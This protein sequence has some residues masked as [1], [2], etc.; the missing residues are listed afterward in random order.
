MT[1]YCSVEV[2]PAEAEIMLENLQPLPT[3]GLSELCQ[4]HALM[5]GRE[6]LNGSKWAL[7]MLDSTSKLQSGL[8][9]GNI[10]E[11]GNFDECLEVD[12]HEEWGS[13]V[14]QHC[15]TIFKFS[16]P[17][18]DKFVGNL[19]FLP[20]I[21]S[22]CMPSTCTPQDLQYVLSKINK[23]FVVDP[24]LCHTKNNG[25]SL[26][27]IDWIVI[28]LFTLIGV[29]CILS[30][31][32]DIFVTNTDRRN[33]ILL[34]FS[35]KTNGKALFNTKDVNFSLDAV[36]GMRFLSICAIVL[37][38]TFAL[39][40]ATP[41]T[42]VLQIMNEARQWKHLYFGNLTFAVD[43]F[44]VISGMLLCY[45]TLTALDAGTKFNIPVFYIHRFLRITPLLGSAI[46]L[47][48]SFLDKLGSGPI[49]NFLNEK[50]NKESCVENWWLTILNVQNYVHFDKEC[51]SSS[52]F[53]AVDTQ[54]F[55]ISPIF[56]L[57][58]HKW[59]KF[60]LGL[61]ITTG[62]AGII[63]AFVE[64][65]TRQDDA[66]FLKIKEGGP[67]GYSY[68][69]TH[70]RCPSWFVGLLCGYLLHR[71]SDWRKRVAT[72]TDR[73]SKV[74][75]TLGW[76]LTI[77]AL[78]AVYNSLYP[79]LQKDHKYDVL[80]AAFYCALT[81]PVWSICM[82]WIIF[83]CVSGYG[84]I[85][86]TI[87]S[88]KVWRPLGRLAF[89]MYI[90]HNDVVFSRLAGTKTP[91]YLSASGKAGEFVENLVLTILVSIVMTLAIESPMLQID[92]LLYRKDRRKMFTSNRNLPESVSIDTLNTSTKIESSE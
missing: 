35:W 9:Q 84:G 66:N 67:L 7:Q 71:T 29:L 20:I 14:G 26:E 77:V 30:T 74:T 65:Y 6:A 34:L 31:L 58:L 1:F 89:A 48:V 16:S 12:V 70:T 59:P 64:S 85:A 28:T 37:G 11:L 8:L 39:G 25:R 61:T 49:W 27:T 42:N 63:A 41:S 22:I 73:L 46:L 18:I 3:D 21:Q 23:N 60:G 33:K 78:A 36:H 54:L 79:F 83:A 43:T 52:W 90:F 10:V 44:F 72:N 86:N 51:I 88:W 57:S 4:K 53:L 32:Y 45:I 87:L 40:S 13:F 47:H 38:H 75:V 92:K 81:R 80:Q 55:W 62:I 24:L 50:K 91:V 76:L 19:G 2:V 68:F 15:S 17:K 82:A 5:M 56:L 69:H